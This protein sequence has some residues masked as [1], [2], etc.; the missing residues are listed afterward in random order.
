MVVRLLGVH[1]QSRNL[2]S[3]FPLT[4]EILYI[5]NNICYLEKRQPYLQVHYDTALLGFYILSH[6]L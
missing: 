2:L 4:V 1:I 3:P 6:D 5:G